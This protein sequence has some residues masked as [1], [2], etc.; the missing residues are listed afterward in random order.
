MCNF[1]SGNEFFIVNF[2]IDFIYMD[3][4]LFLKCFLISKC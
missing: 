2:G 1:N 4:Y 3:M